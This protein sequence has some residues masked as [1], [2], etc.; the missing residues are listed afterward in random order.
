[1]TGKWGWGVCG[2]NL[3]KGCGGRQYSG[4]LHKIT[5]LA[6]SANYV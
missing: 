3:K 6:F 4:G 5:G 1:M 2:K